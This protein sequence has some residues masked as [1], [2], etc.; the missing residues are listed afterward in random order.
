MKV[1]ELMNELSKVE[2]GT[3]VS[4][5]VSFPDG[6]A[7]DSGDGYFTYR[8]NLSDVDTDA[9]GKVTLCN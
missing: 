8:D 7:T 4:I 9:S 2:A 6:E 3:E 5:A 1:Y